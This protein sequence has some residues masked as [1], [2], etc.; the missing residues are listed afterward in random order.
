MRDVEWTVENG[1]QCVLP[2]EP[3]WFEGEAFV[4]YVIR[5]RSPTT[6]TIIKTK[7]QI[8]N[9]NYIGEYLVEINIRFK[10]ISLCGIERAIGG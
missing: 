7:E 5:Q 4:G 9:V 3:S 10:E 8:E 6:P 1:L 2:F